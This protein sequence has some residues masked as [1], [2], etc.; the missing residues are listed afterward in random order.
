MRSQHAATHPRET[1]NLLNQKP[2]QRSNFQIEV[3]ADNYGRIERSLAC[4]VLWWNLPY[5]FKF[6]TYVGASNFLDLLRNLMTLLF[7]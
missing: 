1:T 3:N 4:R 7:Q 6:S 2:W 5:G